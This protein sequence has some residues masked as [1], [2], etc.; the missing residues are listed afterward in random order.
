[1]RWIG[2]LK[3]HL[4]WPPLEQF[5]LS[6]FVMVQSYL[7]T[8]KGLVWYVV[9]KTAVLPVWFNKQLGEFGTS[10]QM[11][12]WLPWKKTNLLT[13]SRF[14]GFSIFFSW[15]LLEYL[16]KWSDGNAKHQN[17]QFAYSI[18]KRKATFTAA[19]SCYIISSAAHWVTDTNIDLI[20]FSILNEVYIMELPKLPPLCIISFCMFLRV[21]SLCIT[22]QGLSWGTANVTHLLSQPES[23]FRKWFCCNTPCVAKFACDL[24]QHSDASQVI[25]NIVAV[26]ASVLT[27]LS[28]HCWKFGS[29]FPPCCV[30]KMHYTK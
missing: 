16:L 9:I 1:M 20:F 12:L 25:H 5:H 4:L 30:H 26:Q 11:L 15:Y 18:P 21:C 14:G 27:L 10:G 28:P 24:Q 3:F 7:S 17:M 23:V 8:N 6:W 29:G 13:N 22:L 2:T 19:M